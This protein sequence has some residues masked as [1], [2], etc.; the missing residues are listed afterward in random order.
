MYIFFQKLQKL[1]KVTRI[2]NDSVLHLV[3]RSCSK[4]SNHI[5]NRDRDEVKAVVEPPNENTVKLKKKRR[6]NATR[7]LTL[8]EIES[9]PREELITMIVKLDTHN[10]QLKNILQ[11]QDKSVYEDS[12]ARKIVSWDWTKIH[13]RHIL[14]KFYYL[15][16]D[17]QGY[18]IQKNTS[19]TI[20]HFLFEALKK[21]RL[22]ESRQTCNY[23]QCGRTDKGVSALGQVISLD[24]RSRVQPEEQLTHAGIG[25][26]LN[27]CALI[28][29]ALPKQ[30]R[31]IS[32]RPLAT[33]S[34]S[35]RFDCKDRTYRYFFPRGNLNVDKMNDAC[36]YLVGT[37]NFKNFCKVDP[38]KDLIN[39]IRRLD[40][41]EI[42]AASVNFDRLEEFDVLYLEVKGWSFLWHMVRRI[43]SVLV[44][45][46]QDTESPEI[47]KELL[48]VEANRGPQYDLADHL[49][50]IFYTSNFR[51]DHQEGIENSEVLNKW[52]FDEHSLA[53]IIKML[54]RQWIKEN[55][56]STMVYEMLKVLRHEYFSQFPNQQTLQLYN[57]QKQVIYEKVPQIESEVQQKSSMLENL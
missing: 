32:W 52:I 29:G 20:E 3:K 6:L 36:K 7:N 45:V 27:Y 25:S 38:S 17:Y 15:G 50:L 26:E 8:K 46:G 39:N 13:K 1:N 42:K 41:V 28:N 19:N 12:E 5:E 35:A 11:K 24:V 2:K 40:S 44:L 53:K 22:I 47:V 30:I 54:Q 48:D 18:A 33:P 34:Y 31:A 37:H 43:V 49:P 56:K 23:H 57:D 21:V 4:I 14:L 16:W 55:A 51:D 9:L 10:Q